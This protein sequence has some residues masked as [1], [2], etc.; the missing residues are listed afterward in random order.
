MTQWQTV[1]GVVDV[2]D[3]G[4][5]LPH[6]HLFIDWA[7]WDAFAPIEAQPDEVL[8]M[9]VPY[10]R[11]AWEAGVT[12]MI[13]CTPTGA[14]KPEIIAALARETPMAIVMPVGLYKEAVPPAQRT[15]SEDEVAA[16]MVGE[17]TQGIGDTDIRAGFIKLAVSDEAITELERKNLRAA[18]RAAVE[19]GVIVASHTSGPHSGDHALE[20]LEILTSQGLPGE[21]FNWVHAQHGN[22]AAHQQAAEA[23][24]YIGFDALKPEDEE[25]FVRLVLDALGAGLVERILLSHDA[26]WYRAEEP[27]GGASQMR[28]Y[29]YLSEGFLP[30]LRNEG[31]GEDALRQMTVLNPRRA[32]R[33]R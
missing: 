29:T 33:L 18:A 12:G 23:G 3:L 25:R 4:L 9:M 1:L 22:L 17:I 20:E 6:E 13:E 30:R 2:D 26:G 21:Q 32:F 28:G 14:Q 10:L 7:A 15:M 11:E 31:V 24:A 5:V 19:T 8:P 16:W 27:D